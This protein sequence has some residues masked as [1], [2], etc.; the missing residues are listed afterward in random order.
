MDNPSQKVTVNLPEDTLAALKVIAQ[1]NGIT[2]TQALRQLIDNQHYLHN[3]VSKGSK[4]LLETD[5]KLREVLL[6]TSRPR[7]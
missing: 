7:T 6:S 2:M 5:G 3:Q 1:D 4:V